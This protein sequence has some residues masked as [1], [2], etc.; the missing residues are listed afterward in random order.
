MSKSLTGHVYFNNDL[1]LY[2]TH[3]HIA[4]SHKDTIIFFPGFVILQYRRTNRPIDRCF[5]CLFFLPFV[6]LTVPPTWAYSVAAQSGC[7]KCSRKTGKVNRELITHAC[8]Q[9]LVS[10]KIRFPSCL[11]SQVK[12]CVK[13][14]N[15]LAHSSPSVETAGTDC[16]AKLWIALLYRQ[17]TSI[18]SLLQLRPQ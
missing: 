1:D 8:S 18:W 17:P 5:F 13:K 11:F 2:H 7:K 9:W 6:F 15:I 12:A 14:E 16:R 4:H 10:V 3:T